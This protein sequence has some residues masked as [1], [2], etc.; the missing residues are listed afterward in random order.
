MER[1]DPEVD[2]HGNLGNDVRANA[3][4][5]AECETDTGN[6]RETCLVIG[7]DRDERKIAIDVS[8]STSNT[9]GM[10]SDTKN[11]HE[12]VTDMHSSRARDTVVAVVE[13]D[14]HKST[15]HPALLQVQRQV[16]SCVRQEC[17]ERNENGADTQVE[18][19]RTENNVSEC[20]SSSALSPPLPPPGSE[21]RQK[22]EDD[23]NRPITTTPT[24]D[25]VT[26]SFVW[27][28]L[29]GQDFVDAI[30]SAYAEVVH[31]RRN[32]FKIPWGSAGKDFVQETARLIRSFAEGSALAPVS[33]KAAM[34]LPSLA[35]QKPPGNS[36]AKD[37]V[38]HLS[39]R[40]RAWRSGD[41]EDLV[42]E[43][44]VIQQHLQSRGHRGDSQLASRFSKLML[45]GKTKAALR[46]LTEEGRGQVL[47]LHAL[48]DP[49]NPASDTVLDSLKAKHPSAQ[50]CHAE[51]LLDP[52][53][54]QT[55]E[56][57]PVIFDGL[58]GEKIRKTALRCNGS[59]GPSGL[60]A[61]MWQR[62]CTAFRGASNDLC[63]S[64]ALLSRRICTD[65]LN[66]SS[67]SA[68]VACRLI[69]L[70]K[71]P[72]VRPIGV[73]EVLRRIVG[74]AIMSIISGDVQRAAGD[75]QLCAGQ[76][77]GCEAA[78]HA[79]RQIFDSAGSEGVL[80]VDASNAFNSLNRQVALH[81]IKLLCPTIST[82]LN[83]TY[84]D[85]AQLFVDHQVIFSEEGTTQGDPL[86]MALY[87][88]A[89]VPLAQR[90]KVNLAGEAWFADDAAGSGQLV[91]LRAWWDN[92]VRYGPLYGYYPNGTKT[93]LIV[94]ESQLDSAR[95]IFAGTSVQITSEGQRHLGAPLGGSSFVEKYTSEKVRG[96]VEQLEKLST[97]AETDPQVAYCAYVH[98]FQSK[99]VY[100]SRTAPGIQDLL[101]PLEDILSNRFIPA[102]TGHQPDS[103][104]RQL[105]ALPAR[106]GGLGLLDPTIA[107]GQEFNNSIALSAKLVAVLIQQCGDLPS[108]ECGHKS[109]SELHQQRRKSMAT[110]AATLMPKL[111]P[112][113]RRCATIASERGSS[114]WLTALPLEQHGF[115]LSKG[116][117][118]DA[119][120][121]RYGW[122]L[123]GVP[124]T[125]ICGHA[126]TSDHALSCPTGGYPSIRHNHVRDV[127]ANLMRE[128]CTDVST[129]PHLQPLTGEVF[130]R[131]S[132]NTTDEA[133]LDIR[134]RGFWECQQECTFFDVR[135]F[136]PCAPSYRHLP[137]SSLYHQQEEQKRRQYEERVQ[138]V[139]RSSFVPLIFTTSSSCSALTTVALKRLAAALSVARNLDYAITMGWLR[140]R[141][142]F[143]LLRSAIMCMRGTRSR[144]TFRATD[145]PD[146]ACAAGRVALQ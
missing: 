55:P 22:T 116:A 44:R 48:S 32:L 54:T 59:A 141:L 146:L 60:D 140:C 125:C 38:A 46:L 87:A 5:H 129:E 94:K 2:Q 23:L 133:R 30:E 127:L 98:G 85:P 78:V 108:P 21:T 101:R 122:D 4:A 99:W 72:G 136:N 37:H 26:F 17:Q 96:W 25:P 86:A 16:A 105:F 138:R 117:F 110:A 51:A 81:N 142:S 83:N 65:D 34:L 90:C 47:S 31:W 68:Y 12:T 113:L 93:W 70:D 39:R 145:I 62:M 14:G 45:E 53:T 75:Q 35:L 27:G 58:T 57:H 95:N 29:V 49:N 91:Q 118:R 109:R 139:E 9:H 63:N 13:N 28:N 69:A 11:A 135:V 120:R 134:A 112:N 123:D 92:L 103:L 102:L 88:L 36:R 106:H 19:C 143:C 119:I 121:L 80:L 3:R 50:P 52:L 1:D 15:S 6:A 89:T 43:G 124:T 74:K 82:V 42:R 24:S 132:T 144:R 71:S 10:A 73:A 111:P 104:T 76:E 130:D 126:F 67:L 20:N 79:L 40:L 84:H 7:A 61:S 137:L 131:A 97:I 8:V 18:Q 107:A 64:V 100:L 66:S 33:L 41:I 56:T 77:A 115:A 128:V 114:S